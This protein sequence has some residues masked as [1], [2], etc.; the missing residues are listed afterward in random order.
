MLGP[1]VAG[2]IRPTW[3]MTVLQSSNAPLNLTG[4]TF[5]GVLY[6]KQ[7]ATATVLGGSF[8]ISSAAD[9]IFVYTP[10]AADTAQKG[11]FEVEIKITIATFTYY[12]RTPEPL[13]ILERWAT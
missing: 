11:V 6:D 4:A 10:V 7:T 8:A 12:L 2:A 9:G 13:I 3:T 1:I 5:A